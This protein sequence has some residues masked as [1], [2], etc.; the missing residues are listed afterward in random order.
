MLYLYTVGLVVGQAKILAWYFDIWMILLHILKQ[1]SNF[2]V[3][4]FIALMIY[5][6]DQGGKWVKNWRENYKVVQFLNVMCKADNKII[7]YSIRNYVN[8][9][10]N[11]LCYRKRIESFGFDNFIA[12]S[13]HRVFSI[14][15]THSKS[16]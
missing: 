13:N 8:Y 16:L 6:S 12:I 7:V 10:L 4:L 1:N 5:L 11:K 15:Q 3:Y 9:N 2:R 14:Y